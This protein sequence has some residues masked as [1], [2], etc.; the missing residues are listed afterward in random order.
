MYSRS[1]SITAVDTVWLERYRNPT[2]INACRSCERKV[3]LVLED[4]VREESRIGIEVKEVSGEDIVRETDDI[5]HSVL[6][7]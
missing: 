5:I 2:L 4:L 1:E 6:A 7:K 3:S